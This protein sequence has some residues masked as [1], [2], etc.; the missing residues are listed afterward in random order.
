VTDLDVDGFATELL[1]LGPFD[2]LLIL[3]SHEDEAVPVLSA[4]VITLLLATS[5]N[6]IAPS[7]LKSYFSWLCTLCKKSHTSMQDLGMQY[8]A[9]ALRTS[10]NRLIFWEDVTCSTVVVEVLKAQKD[11]Q[12]QYHTLLVVWLITF[13]PKIAKELNKSI[14]SN[15]SH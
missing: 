15:S 11:L 12:V 1:S 5:P 3:V 8:F 7:S 10:R 14:S 4:Q 13:E 6:S 9:G 2:P